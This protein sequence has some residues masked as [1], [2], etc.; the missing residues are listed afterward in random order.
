MSRNMQT[1]RPAGPI[2]FVA[3]LIATVMVPFAAVTTVAAQGA[4]PT[5]TITGPILATAPIGDPSHGFVFSP[6]AVDLGPRGYVQE[7]F[8]I[9]GT[10]N[11][12]TRSGMETA[13]VLDGGHPY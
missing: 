13:D 8:F 1:E 10:A 9:E 4:D 2:R 5:P 3:V 12:Y 6:A 11:R 7:E